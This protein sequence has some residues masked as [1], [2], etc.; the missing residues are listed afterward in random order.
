MCTELFSSYL[1]LYRYMVQLNLPSGLRKNSIDQKKNYIQHI[2]MQRFVRYLVKNDL[3]FIVCFPA[4]HFPNHFI[5]LK[6][7]SLSRK[8]I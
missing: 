3:S 5:H 8:I 1:F 2:L 4:N 6:S 7:L